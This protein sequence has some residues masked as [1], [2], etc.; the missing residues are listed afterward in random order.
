MIPFP[1]PGC[2]PARMLSGNAVGQLAGVAVDLASSADPAGRRH[3]AGGG[4]SQRDRAAGN[5]VFRASLGD[6]AGRVHPRLG[7]GL[8]RGARRCPGGVQ[9][10]T[11]ALTP[12]ASRTR[13]L[14]RS[15]RISDTGSQPLPV[16]KVE[17]DSRSRGR[18]PEPPGAAADG[19]P[20]RREP[21]PEPAVTPVT[22][23]GRYQYLKWWKLVLVIVGVWIAAA[24]VGLSLFYWWFHTIDKTGPVFMVLVYV[25]TCTVAGVL[26]AMVQGR[27]LISALALGGDD[28]AVR[29]RPGCGAALRLLLLPANWPLPVQ[30]HSLLSR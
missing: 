26:L 22:V 2:W 23:P 25:V 11:N 10:L 30:C 17:D 12:S 7:A 18:E 13:G 9:W 1:D 4:C 14:S 19:E 3:C 24:E 21:A 16:A 27:P 8:V 20:Q 15:C 28:G 5:L 29:F 6:A